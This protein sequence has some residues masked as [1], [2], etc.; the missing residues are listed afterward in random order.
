VD[1]VF[2]KLSDTSWNFI[3]FTYLVPQNYWWLLYIIIWQSSYKS[4]K[5]LSNNI[6]QQFRAGINTAGKIFERLLATFFKWRIDQL[7]LGKVD[8]TFEK[9]VGWLPKSLFLFAIG[10]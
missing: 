4:F 3:L 2:F 7:F 9:F 10:Y 1:C 8:N 6:R 5:K